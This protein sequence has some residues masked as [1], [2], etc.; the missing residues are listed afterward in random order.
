MQEHYDVVKI[1]T[2]GYPTRTSSATL[3]F[4][5]DPPQLDDAARAERMARALEPAPRYRT[6]LLLP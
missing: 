4:R 3:T 2:G 5:H 1:A 6:E